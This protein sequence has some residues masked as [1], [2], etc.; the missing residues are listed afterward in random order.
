ME[1]QSQNMSQPSQM[2]TPAEAVDESNI[3][4]VGFWARVLASII[5]T[6]LL[7]IILIPLMLAFGITYMG[8]G[9]V[10]V[11]MPSGLDFLL[12]YVFPAVAIILFW[13]YKS[14]TPGKMMIGA[15]IA[16]AKTYGKPSTGQCIG[17]YFAYIVSTI[18]L[19]LGFIWIA[20]DKRK[21]GWHD[22]LAGTVVIKKSP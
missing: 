4:Y 8:P 2:D 12:N 20:F 10:E 7:L 14:A 21:R 16:D 17:R 11:I 19:C 5:D 15:I 22:Y 13:V 1:Q 9:S 3:K 6:I 18:P